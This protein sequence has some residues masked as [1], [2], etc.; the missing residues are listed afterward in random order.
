MAK[1]LILFRNFLEVT[2]DNKY[3]VT[4]IFLFFSLQPPIPKQ[5]WTQ[6]LNATDHGPV[7]PQPEGKHTR[8]QMSEDCLYL[9]V[10]VPANV[11]QKTLPVLVYIH[12]GSFKSNSGNIDSFYGPEF[13][14]KRGI[15]YVSMNYRFVYLVFFNKLHHVSK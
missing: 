13:F 3:V 8:D 7:C 12:G 9:N 5:A 11:T 1:K 2:I 6:V 10:I 4:I 15:I 14:V